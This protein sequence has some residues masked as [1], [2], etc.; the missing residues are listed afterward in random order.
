M[1]ISTVDSGNLAA[2]LLTLRAGLASFPDEKI[3]GPKVF[4]GLTDTLSILMEAAGGTGSGPA[5]PDQE[6]GSEILCASLG[7]YG[8]GHTGK[9]LISSPHLLWKLFKA[10]TPVLTALVAWWARTFAGQCRAA[11]DDLT[12]LAP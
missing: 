9:A 12:C 2:H 5:L 11:L 6:G 10:L 4:N 1:Y 3:T 7:G 8:G